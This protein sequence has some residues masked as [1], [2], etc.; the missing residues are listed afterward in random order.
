[1]LAK[2]VFTAA[3]AKLA[4]DATLRQTIGAA[5][6]AL[7]IAEYDEAKMF[8]RYRQLYGNAMNRADFARQA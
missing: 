8:A 6:Q 1:M 7:A 5:N 2:S 4:G 3:L